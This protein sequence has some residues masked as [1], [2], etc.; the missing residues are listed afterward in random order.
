MNFNSRYKYSILPYFGSVSSE[1][2]S[3]PKLPVSPTLY[4]VYYST[5]INLIVKFIGNTKKK[6]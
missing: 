2:L 3:Y 1:S 5:R 6:I 4:F